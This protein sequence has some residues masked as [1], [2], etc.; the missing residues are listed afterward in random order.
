[1]AAP[2]EFIRSIH[3]FAAAGN[4]FGAPGISTGY[5]FLIVIKKK[6]AGEWA[7]DIGIRSSIRVSNAAFTRM[8]PGPKMKRTC[9]LPISFQP[10]RRRGAAGVW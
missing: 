2:P 7:D 6:S 1:M 5:Q 4:I 3:V 8:R 10:T 9:T